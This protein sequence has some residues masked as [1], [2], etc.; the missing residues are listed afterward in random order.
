MVGGLLCE[1]EC[2]QEY[3]SLNKLTD[4]RI[5]GDI[6]FI[7]IK[8]NLREWPDQISKIFKIRTSN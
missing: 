5:C 8:K 2:K 7:M 3:S 1:N 6:T 4:V